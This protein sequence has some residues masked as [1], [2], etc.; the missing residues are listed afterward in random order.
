MSRDEFRGLAEMPPE[1]EWF[2]NLD[3]ARTRAAYKIDVGEFMR[4]VGIARPEEFRD[5]VAIP[6]Y[7]QISLA[8]R[9][10]SFLGCGWVSGF[11]RT[12]SIN[13]TQSRL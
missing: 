1:A 2:A 11:S 8:N 7:R 4:F 10:V 6:Q 9:G 3:S 13:G 5:V 12:Y